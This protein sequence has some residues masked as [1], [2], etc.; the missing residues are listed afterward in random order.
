VKD[1]AT[2]L[3]GFALA[4]PQLPGVDLLMVGDGPLRADLENLAAELRVADRVKFLG[5]RSD[6]PAVMRAAD[7]FALTSVS[8]AASL[9]LLEAMASAL[10]VVATN[11]GGNMELARPDR[12]GLLFPR[13]DAAGCA[14]ALV[15][16]FTEPE[17]AAKLGGAGRSRA[18]ERY[19][20]SRTVEEYYK[21]YQ[22][23]TGR[24]R[25]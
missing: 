6:I 18:L 11:V 9:T 13:G 12:E 10:P 4:A 25:V 20:L 16:L 8:E 2:L 19:Q 22:M 21:L 24:G 23:V 7:A 14:A 1:Q 17:L 15:R 3:R 5:I